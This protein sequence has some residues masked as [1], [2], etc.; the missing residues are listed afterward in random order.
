MFLPCYS[1]HLPS[2][3]A[4]LYPELYPE[5][6]TSPAISVGFS[7]LKLLTS[8]MTSLVAGSCDALPNASRLGDGYGLKAKLRP[9]FEDKVLVCGFVIIKVEG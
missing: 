6:T 8:S 9:G 4:I 1:S 5:A 3:T 7:L 2:L